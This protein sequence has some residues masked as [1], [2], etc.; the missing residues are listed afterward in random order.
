MNEQMT[1]Q[2]RLEKIMRDVIEDSYAGETPFTPEQKAMIE[3]YFLE[4][5]NERTN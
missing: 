1:E 2:Q 5:K 3:E 4:L